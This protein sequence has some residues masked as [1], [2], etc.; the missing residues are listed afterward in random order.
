[1]EYSARSNVNG[2]QPIDSTEFQ[3]VNG[4]EY[5][6]PI[7]WLIAWANPLVGTN[8]IPEIIHEIG[9]NDPDEIYDDILQGIFFNATLGPVDFDCDNPDH[10]T[11]ASEF[12]SVKLPG[13]AVRASLSDN[14]TDVALV[15]QTVPEPG[16]ITLLALGAGGLLLKRRRRRAGQ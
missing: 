3:P 9:E 7:T 13:D 15:Q 16:T 11:C 4:V 10:D 14:F 5:L 6:G 12:L 8:P 1:M 2:L